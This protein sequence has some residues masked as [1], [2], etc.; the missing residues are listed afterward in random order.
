MRVFGAEA[1]TR[2]FAA[3]TLG[4]EQGPRGLRAG[5]RVHV[6][7]H[8]TD[9]FADG[10]LHVGC[11]LLAGRHGEEIVALDNRAGSFVSYGGDGV[12]GVAGVPHE[13][14]LERGA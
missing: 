14:T 11:S 1:S 6:R 8:L 4:W 3:S 13:L 10:R 12:Y 2:V 5:E 9:V 7:V